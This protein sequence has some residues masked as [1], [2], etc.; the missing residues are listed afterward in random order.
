MIQ[1]LSFIKYQE[2]SLS[3]D[4]FMINP[5]ISHLLKHS[6]RHLCAFSQAVISTCETILIILKILL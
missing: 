2:T 3:S 4:L 1:F 5:L 6:L